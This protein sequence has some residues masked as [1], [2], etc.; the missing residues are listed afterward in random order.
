MHLNM[1]K[2]DTSYHVKTL[3][4][5]SKDKKNPHQTNFHSIL[6]KN[7]VWLDV[8]LIFIYYFIITI[9]VTYSYINEATMYEYVREICSPFLLQTS[10]LFNK[11]LKIAIYISKLFLFC[12]ILQIRHHA[13]AIH[14]FSS[15]WWDTCR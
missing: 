14:K 13:V 4:R 9:Y 11:P 6:Y 5:K 8:T 3:E 15:S 10:G 2:N 1:K 7:G 12:K